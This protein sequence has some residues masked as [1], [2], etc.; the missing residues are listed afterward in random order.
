M[1]TQLIIAL[2]A[3]SRITDGTVTDLWFSSEQVHLFDPASGE[4]LTRYGTQPE[5]AAPSDQLVTSDGHAS[6]EQP[7]S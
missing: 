4:N 1:R 5:P 6:T 3:E 2:S 7:E